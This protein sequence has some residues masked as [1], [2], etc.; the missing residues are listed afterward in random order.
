[1]YSLTV[2]SAADALA[3]PTCSEQVHGS[4]FGDQTDKKGG[5]ALIY[6]LRQPVL[7]S[8]EGSIKELVRE[9]KMEFGISSG[10]VFQH[11][12]KVCPSLLQPEQTTSFVRC[13]A[14]GSIF[15]EAGRIGSVSR[16]LGQFLAMCPSFWHRWHLLLSSESCTRPPRR[17]LRSTRSPSRSTIGRFG[18][19]SPPTSA[20][21]LAGV[22]AS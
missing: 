19:V 10:C 2:P 22:D 13:S 18:L 5:A 8:S 20:I 15:I 3:F 21:V 17:S 6:V 16:G 4:M 7:K 9:L 11:C 14:S 1:M 12:A